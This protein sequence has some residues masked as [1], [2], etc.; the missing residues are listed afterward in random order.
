VA[1][2]FLETL[3]VLGDDA[4]HARRFAQPAILV[5]GLHFLPLARLFAYPPHFVTG[6]SLVALALAY[7][8]LAPS[9]PRSGLAPLGAGMILWCSAAWAIR[10]VRL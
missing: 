4:Q 7:P 1:S 5:V 10:P 9:G 2:R 8:L 6:A 3:L